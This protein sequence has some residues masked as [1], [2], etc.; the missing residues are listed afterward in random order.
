MT[1]ADLA[2]TYRGY[3]ACLNR[4]DWPDLAQFVDPEVRHNDRPLGLPG[5]RAMLEADVRA[6]PDLRFEIELL[7]AEPPRLASRLRFDCH[8]AGVLFGLP[9]NGRRVVFAENV[10]YEFRG[11]RIVQVWSVI[12][13]AAIAAQL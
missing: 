10:F 2:D 8:P 5:Y 7:L 4:R 9:V 6:I 1:P 13:K 3:I 12:D 11:G